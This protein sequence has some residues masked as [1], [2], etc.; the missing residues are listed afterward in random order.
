MLTESNFTKILEAADQLLIED[1][2]DLIKILQNRLRDKRRSELIK[3]V[4]EAQR[5]ICT[6]T[7]PAC[8][9][10]TT[11]AGASIMKFI[12]LRSNTFV[13]SAKKF[14]KKHLEIAP[15]LQNALELLSI[16]PFHPRLKTHK[17]KGE[18]QDSWACSGG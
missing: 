10:R 12:L 11:N 7:M 18:F 16:E 14:L 13:R 1:Q 15:N 2:E 17:L 8:K 6:G 4:Q 9:P 3:E 5:R